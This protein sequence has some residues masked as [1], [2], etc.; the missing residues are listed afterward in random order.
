MRLLLG[1]LLLLAFAAYIQSERHGCGFAI[2]A[3]LDWLECVTR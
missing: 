3:I 2:R 1:F